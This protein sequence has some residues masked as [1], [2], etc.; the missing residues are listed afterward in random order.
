M[1]YLPR[2]VDS[3]L[4][5]RL[6]AVGATVIVGP[7]WCGKTTTAKQKAK[8]VLEMQDPD[9]QEG[10]L[11]LAATKL[12]MLLEG[13]KP[14]LIDEWQLAPVLWD[15][16]RVSVDRKNEKGQYLLTG[17][18]VVDEDKIKHTGIGRISR[19]E[20]D[21][22]S[23]F[24]TNESSGDVSLKELFTNPAASVD[25]ARGKLTVEE[26]IFAVCRGG[27]PSSLEAAGD[28]AKLFVATDYFNNVVEVDISRIDGFERDSILAAQLLKSY[29]RNI[30]TLATKAS[31]RKDVLSVREVSMPTVDSYLSALRKLFVINDIDAWCPAIRSA[32]D[33][34]AS[35]KRGFFDPSIAVAAMGVGP[36]YFRTDFKT[37]GFLFESLVM[38]DLRVYS[39]AM[40]GRISYYRDRYGLEADAVLHLKDGR[41]A[42]IE[43]K[44]GSSEIEKGAEHLKEVRRL[45]GKY[46][47]TE[48]QCP[49]R[50]PDLL[51][52]ITGG[53]YAY[54]RED[55]VIVCPIS[56]LKD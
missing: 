15:A 5:L 10:Y 38:R 21:T 23:L 56:A 2:I 35:C 53:D 3:E 50:M 4:D 39:H 7:K 13:A 36:E 40:G 9:L 42:L 48:K 19:L 29:A 49:L 52:V 44:L 37:F 8:S 41:Y 34:R 14:R 46:N 25:G 43:I 11:K 33:I 20:M 32:T 51:M 6:R 55:G 27:W 54:T 12:S 18:V 45:I 1:N 26:L 17:S 22:M 28:D 30:S 24:E 47:K 16:V 31:I